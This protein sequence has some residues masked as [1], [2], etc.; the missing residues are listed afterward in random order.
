MRLMLLPFGIIVKQYAIG[1]CRVGGKVAGHICMVDVR[2]AWENRPSKP[3]A[4]SAGLMN[5]E[6]AR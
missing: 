5:L 2:M 4:N 6:A 3:F 1:A